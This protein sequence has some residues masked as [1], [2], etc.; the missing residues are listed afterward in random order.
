MNF[1][2]FVAIAIICIGLGACTDT[3]NVYNFSDLENNSS[4][5]TSEAK[6]IT[7]IPEDKVSIIVNSKNPQIAAIFNLPYTTRYIGGANTPSYNQGVAGYM[8]DPDGFIDFPV[9]GKIPAAG[10]TRS[11][12]AYYIKNRL[13]EEEQ[14]KDPV[15]TVEYM[16]LSFQ[17]LGEV[18][19]PGRY[20]IERDCTTLLD[21]IS[22]AGDLTIYGVREKVIVQRKEGDEVKT[23]VVNLNSAQD[24]YKSPAYYI[25]QNDI[26]YVEPNNV[27]ARQSTVNGNNVR[28]TSF[29]IS[30]ASLLT[31]ITSTVTVIATR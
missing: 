3:K 24:V 30:L 23:Y 20:D 17:V 9:L 21:A 11:E 15:V 7:F 1:K 18:K 26:I 27:R 19:S 22:R 31:S 10:K 14:I 2:H 5:Q 29:W 8:V 25:H 13:I 6:L 28:S 4:I 12:L 16:N